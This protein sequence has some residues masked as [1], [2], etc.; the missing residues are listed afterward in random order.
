MPASLMTN[1]QAK[2]IKVTSKDTLFGLSLEL[3]G[4]LVDLGTVVFLSQLIVVQ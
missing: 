3:F 4:W 1:K 2:N